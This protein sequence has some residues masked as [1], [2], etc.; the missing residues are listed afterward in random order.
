MGIAHDARVGR[1]T[2]QIFFHKIINHGIPKILPNIQDKMGKTERNGNLP[3]IVDRIQAATSG[4]FAIAPGCRIIPGLH[5]QADD[6]MSLLMQQ[7]GRHGR[8]QTTAH[9]HKHP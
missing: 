9:G 4:F 7:S 1:S 5:G 6:L 3:G 8:V 2:S